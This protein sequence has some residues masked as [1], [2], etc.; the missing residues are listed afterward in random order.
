MYLRK[1]L[2]SR[3]VL[4]PS[5]ATKS[6]PFVILC[7]VVACANLVTGIAQF[8]PSYINSLNN[9][10]IAT[11]VT[12]AGLATFTMAGQ[13]ICKFILGASVDFSPMKAVLAACGLGIVAVLCV[14]LAPD[15]PLLPAGGFLFGMFYATPIVLT[16][17]IAGA[18][19]GTGQ[20]YSVIWGRTLL[21][22]GLLAAPSG[23]LWPWIAETF[24]GYGAVFMVG[25]TLIA[26]FALGSYA[27]MK[28]GKKLPHIVPEAPNTSKEPK[29]ETAE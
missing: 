4:D 6:A 14:Y 1:V 13:A 27:A 2:R 28:L 7:L 3:T 26:L 24:G 9:L 23:I 12:G 22:S 19:F 17:L 21:P 8:F 20:E 5:I 29:A 18:I 16:P 15:T 10:G 11:F 25:I